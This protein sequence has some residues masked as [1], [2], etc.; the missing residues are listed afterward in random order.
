[1]SKHTVVELKDRDI[2]TDPLTELL[3][4]GA[5]K[6]IH[7]AVE[8]ELQERKNGVRSCLLPIT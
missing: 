2:D 3:R 8:L 7:Q 5:R 1:M 4:T 6:L